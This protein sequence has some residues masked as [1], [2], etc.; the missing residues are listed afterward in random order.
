MLPHDLLP[1][2]TVYDYFAKWRDDGT[3][4]KINDRLVGAIRLL[5]APGEEME[6]SA[7][8]IDSQGA[9]AVATVRGRVTTRSS[10]NPP[11]S[12]RLP[13]SRLCC[14]RRRH[15][16]LRR[17]TSAAA[18]RVCQTPEWRLAAQSDGL[19]RG[20]WAGMPRSRAWHSTCTTVRCEADVR[21]PMASR[22][23]AQFVRLHSVLRRLDRRRPPPVTRDR[24]AL[25]IG[26][27]PTIGRLPCVDDASPSANKKGTD[28][29]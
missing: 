24:H 22:S 26:Q 18:D 6:P 29:R 17:L 28:Y 12:G 14:I 3:L 21:R 16:R 19:S 25:A 5:E 8:S 10:R 2:S 27:S 4:R 7:G 11:V 23:L 1:K 20:G 13:F 15:S 9:P